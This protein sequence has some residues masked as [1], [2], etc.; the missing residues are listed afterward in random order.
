MPIFKGKQGY[1]KTS[2]KWESL[3]EKEENLCDIIESK[4]QEMFQERRYYHII[5]KSHKQT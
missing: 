4:L 1:R 2:T 5:F 3:P